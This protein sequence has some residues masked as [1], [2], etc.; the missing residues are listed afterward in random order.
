MTT[1]KASE[2]LALLRTFKKSYKEKYNTTIFS[3]GCIAYTFNNVVGDVL[4][5]LLPTKKDRELVVNAINSEQLDEIEE[6]ESEELISG[7]FF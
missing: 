4:N 3:L 7:K 6:T 5:W 1:D 2:N